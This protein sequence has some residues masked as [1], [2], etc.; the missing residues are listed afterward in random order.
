MA[1]HSVST[2]Q[3]QNVKNFKISKNF[4]KKKSTLASQTPQHCSNMSKKSAKK[5]AV[6]PAVVN[7]AVLSDELRHALGGANSADA[8]VLPSQKIKT[9]VTRTK[10]CRESTQCEVAKKKKKKDF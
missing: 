7:E 8:L 5:K 9:K 10:K 6:Q 3:F 4:Q 1:G 2:F